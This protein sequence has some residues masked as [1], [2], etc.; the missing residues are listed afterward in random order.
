MSDALEIT[1]TV[2][3][4]AASF[5]AP[6]VEIF[7]KPKLQRLSKFLKRNNAESLISVE[8]KF[9]EYL[10]RS[11]EKHSYIPILIFQNQQK[12]LEDI[13]IPLTV[14]KQ[15]EPENFL[16]DTYPK[17]FLPKYKK[18]LIRDTAGMGK[19]T[20]MKKLFLSSLEMQQGIPIFIEL[21]KLKGDDSITS[22]IHR[23]L[24]PI[25]DEFDQE[26]ILNLIKDGSF[27]FF[28]D[29]YDEI[30]QADREKVTQN[31]HDFISK[32]G[33][34]LF[35][36]T[37]RPE[38]SLASFPDFMQFDIQPL[39]LEEAFSLLRKYDKCGELAEEIISKLK[40]KTLESVK[41]FLTNPLLA[42]LLYKSYEYKHTIPLKKHVF[43]RQ[44][45]DALY[46]SHD[47][48]KEGAYI[49]EKYCQL[50]SDSFHTVLRALG[51]ITLKHGVEYN[52][53]QI[54]SYLK[55][56]KVQCSI[57][58]FKESKF[59]DDLLKTVPLFTIEG[60]NFKWSH[61]SLQDYFAAQFIWLDSNEKKPELL[62]R[63][64]KSDENRK[65]LNVL[66]LYY[67]MDY[68]SFRQ[69]IIYDYLIEAIEHYEL[70]TVIQ[71][72]DKWTEGEL[73]YIKSNIFGQS[74]F[75]IPQEYAGK[76]DVFHT[77][78]ELDSSIKK[79]LREKGFSLSGY[80]IQLWMNEVDENICVFG[81]HNSFLTGLLDEKIEKLFKK[82]ESFLQ[83]NSKEAKRKIESK[84][85]F[86]GFTPSL[87]IVESSMEFNLILE[88]EFFSKVFS[89]ISIDVNKCRKMKAEI[90]AEIKKEASNALFESF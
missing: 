68:K 16:L 6:I 58:E 67:D 53:D 83:K 17:K 37:S 73:N 20:L 51:F 57:I 70:P 84:R 34:N 44:V 1:K 41:D 63:M 60:N 61:K 22:F 62:R 69:I 43:Y 59:L 35:I 75:I 7:V 13:Y 39:K 40:G 4:F 89:R 50:D 33:K 18:I 15:R 30:A 27:I 24:N 49:R 77:K 82:N 81:N 76:L 65:Y 45:Y 54:L 48:T 79:F 78:E 88:N 26:F 2:A 25:N 55:K 71:A 86:I 19:S 42:S 52:K 14:R 8:A 3:P 9:E 31:L 10:N 64:V 72:T 74:F 12:K 36:M 66:D 11:Y 80:T 87:I 21:R 28:L 5:I 47:L 56:A 38:T 46:E 23:E 32:T 85:G 90:E 29:G